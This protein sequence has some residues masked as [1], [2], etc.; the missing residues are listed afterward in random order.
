MAVKGKYNPINEGEFNAKQ[1]YAIELLAT[2]NGETLTSICALVGISNTQL[3]KWRRTPA[4]QKAVLEL[5]YDM[6]KDGLPEV[7]RALQYKAMAGDTKAMDLYL[8]YAGDF[9]K[10]SGSDNI[11]IEHS[12]SIDLYSHLTDEELDDLLDD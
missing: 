7:Y 5:A 8:K 12:G 4:F 10:K 9:I 1:L 2:P 11:K 6:L 3:R